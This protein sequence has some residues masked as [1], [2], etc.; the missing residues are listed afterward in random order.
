M[1]VR[2][3]SDSDE[4]QWW[5]FG[6]PLIRTE[7]NPETRWRTRFVRPGVIE[8]E[9]T[10]GGRVDD[11]D[12]QILVD[13][14]A[15]EGSIVAHVERLAGVLA[16]IGLTGPG[17]VSIAFRGV[18]DVELTRSRGGGR[19]IRK[20]ELFLPELRADDLSAAMQPQLRDQFNILWQA[21][22]WAD[23]SPSFG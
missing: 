15:L 19:T 1:Q 22:G 12:E 4:R 20:P 8:Y 13:G 7:N 3:Q 18:E 21:S 9:A 14:R 16:A 17:L 2:V 5:S 6:L 11:G 23:G 10:I